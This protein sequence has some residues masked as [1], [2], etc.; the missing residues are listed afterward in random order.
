MAVLLSLSVLSVVFIVLY[1]P[2]LIDAYPNSL[3][4]L[5]ATV[6]AESS[7]STVYGVL[8]ETGVHQLVSACCPC[9]SSNLN[10]SS[11]GIL[12]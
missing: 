1:L 12:L 5:P 2:S 9:G 8:A 4:H 10:R 11:S 3:Y 6:P 7:I